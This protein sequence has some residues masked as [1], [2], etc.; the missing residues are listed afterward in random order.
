M[1]MRATAGLGP[2]N[3]CRLGRRRPRSDWTL[4]G[5]YLGKSVP[6]EAKTR[7]HEIFRGVASP[8]Q[9]SEIALVIS[10]LPSFVITLFH[11]LTLFPT[12]LEGYSN[13]SADTFLSSDSLVAHAAAN[14]PL[15]L[16]PPFLI[17]IRP[18]G[19]PI[20]WEP[21]RIIHRFH[22]LYSQGARSGDFRV[23]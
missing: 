11:P 3:E 12:F 9:R 18:G 21:D 2:L 14:P 8:I 10:D 7:T 16:S 23:W 19:A 20:A 4:R 1:P 5:P 22:R 17:R 15:I 6:L 13:S